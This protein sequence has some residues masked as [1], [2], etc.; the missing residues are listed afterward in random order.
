MTMFANSIVELSDSIGC[1]LRAA[2]VLINT[3]KSCSSDAISLLNVNLFIF[4]IDKDIMMMFTLL[5]VVFLREMIS[6]K[7]EYINK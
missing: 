1:S 4:N 5:N 6:F 3:S 7:Y 2:Y